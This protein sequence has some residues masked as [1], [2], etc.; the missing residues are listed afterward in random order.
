MFEVKKNDIFVNRIGN[1]VKV[2]KIDGKLAYCETIYFKNKSYN[3]VYN[4]WVQNG[5]RQNFSLSREEVLNDEENFHDQDLILKI[6]DHKE[7]P[8]YF[9]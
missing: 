4:F 5:S 6:T 7:Y 1:V 3:K 9:I 8:E 2:I